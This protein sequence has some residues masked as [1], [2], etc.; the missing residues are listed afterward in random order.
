MSTATPASAGGKVRP[1]IVLI[2][3]VREAIDPVRAAFAGSLPTAASRMCLRLWLTSRVKE[4]TTD[5]HMKLGG[6]TSCSK[7]ASL[8]CLVS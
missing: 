3:A 8:I 1:R 5:W 6:A 4:I 2:H 7:I